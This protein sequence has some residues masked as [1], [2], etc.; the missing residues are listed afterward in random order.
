MKLQ[1]ATGL[2]L[3]ALSVFLAACTAGVEVPRTDE[4][5]PSTVT[6]T[7]TDGAFELQNQLADSIGTY[8]ASAEEGGFSGVVLI[9]RNDTIL[10]HRAVG[11]DPAITTSTAFWIGSLTKSLTAAAILKLQE[12]EKLAVAD[13]ISRHLPD[14]PEDKRAI[15][16]HHLLTHTSGLGTHYAADS[17][18]HRDEAIETILDLPLAGATGSFDYS[19]DGYSLLAGVISVVSGRSYE[20]FLSEHVL[21]PAGMRSAGFWWVPSGQSE[22]RVAPVR[23]IPIAA[24]SGGTW[25]YKGASG[26]YA[27]VEDLFHWIQGLKNER[28]LKPFS[29]SV[30]VAPH[31]PVSDRDAY[32]YGWGIEQTDQWG[33]IVWHNGSN[34]ELDHNSNLRWYV[35]IDLIMVFLSNSPEDA[36]MAV[37][38]DVEQTA[39]GMLRVGE[40]N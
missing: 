1:T 18:A 13:P 7:E 16:I 15:T 23:S 31:S 10:V 39:L 6:S 8:L 24:R 25:G 17:V 34:S 21:T 40:D 14:V 28:V 19:N 11:H 32:A 5:V 12:Q 22:S 3:I 35:D 30:M 4:A 36:A 2:R 38:A 27:T 33:R 26:V 20:Q 37:F 9:A 29:V